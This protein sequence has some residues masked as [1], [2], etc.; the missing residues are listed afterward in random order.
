MKRV[1]LKLQVPASWEK[2]ENLKSK[3]R[4]AQFNIP[5]VKGEKGPLELTI[6]SFGGGGGGVQA[7]VERWVNQFDSDGRV[8]GVKRGES[9]QG[10][11]V[12]VDIQGT[13]NMTVGPPIAGK[14]EK[15]PNA[16]MLG[17]IIGVP[18]TGVFYLKLAGPEESVKAQLKNLRT[19]FGA[20]DKEEEIPLKSE[21]DSAP[22]KPDAPTED[23]P[24]SE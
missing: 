19:A 2:E 14:T 21:A 7:N 23:A 1:G 3:L 9:K 20:S 11:Y 4:L 8:A 17:V 10:P 6:F 24:K 16:R 5:A 12:F 15:V 22:A 18:D 13:F